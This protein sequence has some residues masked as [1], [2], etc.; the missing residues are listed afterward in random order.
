M[1]RRIRGSLFNFHP[2]V[3]A[4][5]L[6]GLVLEGRFHELIPFTIR[7]LPLTFMDHSSE[8][9]EISMTMAHLNHKLVL[10]GVPRPLLPCAS[11]PG[12]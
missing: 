12:F 10:G 7:N 6:P 8:A 2:H 4:L 11:A 9:E 3:H 5:V 1:L